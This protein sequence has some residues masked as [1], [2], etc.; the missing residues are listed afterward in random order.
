MWKFRIV[1]VIIGRIVLI[2]AQFASGCSTSQLGED[3]QIDCR[4]GEGG[5][6]HLD[7]RAWTFAKD[8]GEVRPIVTTLQLSL[9][10]KI[11]IVDSARSLGFFSHA[12]QEK[13][14]INEP[15]SNDDLPKYYEIDLGMSHWTAVIRIST[16]DEE[17]WVQWDSRTPGTESW[18][19][20]DSLMTCIIRIIESKPEYKALP[21]GKATM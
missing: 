14:K 12:H 18:R 13:P 2:A 5:K 19:R 11:R 3:I 21:R 8:I 9:A 20:M 15:V 7:T 1:V 6:N 16:V 17:N 10:E 4:W